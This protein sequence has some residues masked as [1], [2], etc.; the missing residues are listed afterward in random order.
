MAALRSFVATAGTT[1]L[2]LSKLA[3]ELDDIPRVDPS[4]AYIFYDCQHEDDA[5][6]AF[7]SERYP[8]AALLGGTSCTGVMSEASLAGGGSIRNRNQA[9][10][11]R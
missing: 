8:N 11:K 9:G 5:I 7:L 6:T 3:T 4:V 1:E 10:G 2:A